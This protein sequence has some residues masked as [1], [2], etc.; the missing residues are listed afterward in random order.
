VVLSTIELVILLLLLMIYIIVLL[1]TVWLQG[2]FVSTAGDRYR[3]VTPPFCTI[4]RTLYFLSKI[5]LNRNKQ[6]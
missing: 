6:C 1:N 2:G 5:F 3:M 4:I